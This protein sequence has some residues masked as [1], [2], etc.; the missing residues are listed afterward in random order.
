M[1]SASGSVTRSRDSDGTRAFAERHAARGAGAYGP[2]RAHRA[3]GMPA[4]TRRL[5]HQRRAPAH[6]SALEQALARGVDLVDTSANYTDGGSERLIGQV[7]GEA[8]RS[9]RLAEP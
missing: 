5:P 3:H 7:V 2:P 6:R 8:I 1:T 9:L 4:G